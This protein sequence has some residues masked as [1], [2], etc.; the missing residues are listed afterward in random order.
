MKAIY[1][2]YHTYEYIDEDGDIDD[3]SKLLGVFSSKEEALK[4]Q[5]TYKGLLDFKNHPDGFLI[6]KYTINKPQCTGGAF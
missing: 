5:A 3:H 4:A 2:L 1:I 6:D